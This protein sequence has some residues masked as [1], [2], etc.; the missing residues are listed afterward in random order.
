MIQGDKKT[1][2]LVI[3][4]IPDKDISSAIQNETSQLDKYLIEL[5]KDGIFIA[6]DFRFIYVN[7]ALESMLN[8]QPHE[9][10]GSPFEMVV[11]EDFMDIW[12]ERYKRRVGTG[13]EPLGRYEVQFLCKGGVKRIWLELQAKRIQYNGK[14]AVLGVVR[15]I[16][17]FKKLQAELEELSK[18]DVLTGLANRSYLMDALEFATASAAR[19]NEKVAVLF[20]DLDGFKQINDTMGHAA[21]DHLLTEAAARLRKLVRNIDTVGRLGGDEFVVI[22][23]NVKR[24]NNSGMVAKKILQQLSMPYYYEGKKMKVSSSIGISH[25]PDDGD[26]SDTLLRKADV[27]LYHVKK[28]GKHGYKICGVEE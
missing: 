28:T 22:L 20:L 25:Y 2:G 24:Q 16:S 23:N 7:P 8:Y 11:A 18:T 9:L 1:S 21:G 19:R 10:V 14:A 17:R 12:L 5:M 27:A 26:D 15:D 6:Q 3:D 13:P 4:C